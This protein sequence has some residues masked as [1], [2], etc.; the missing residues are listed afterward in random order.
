MHKVN[1]FS[2]FSRWE[3]CSLRYSLYLRIHVRTV[4][5]RNG[6]H[7]ICTQC[8]P[9]TH[10]KTEKPWA[11]IYSPFYRRGKTDRNKAHLCRSNRLVTLMDESAFCFHDDCVVLLDMRVSHMY[12][13]SHTLHLLSYDNSYLNR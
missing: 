10:E 2:V 6:A 12:A 8:T 1:V 3:A 7:S 5:G 13:G 11:R 9:G 4:V